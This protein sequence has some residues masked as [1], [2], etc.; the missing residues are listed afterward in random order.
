MAPFFSALAVL[1]S[2]RCG[3]YFFWAPQ[4]K[5]AHL[6]LTPLAGVFLGGDMKLASLYLPL[7]HPLEWCLLGRLHL[8]RVARGKI[9][10]VGILFSGLALK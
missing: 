9:P 6:L 2:S 3:V 5:K 10:P 8:P 4:S 1:C 7:N